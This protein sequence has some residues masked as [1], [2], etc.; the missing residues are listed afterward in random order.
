MAS[1]MPAQSPTIRSCQGPFCRDSATA[2]SGTVPTAVT[3]A[4]AGS[5]KM[6]PPWTT[7]TVDDV[8]RNTSLRAKMR[9]SRSTI[10]LKNSERIRPLVPCPT[11]F[12]STRD[13]FF[14]PAASRQAHSM[15][16]YRPPTTTM[17]FPSGTVPLRTSMPCIRGTAPGRISLSGRLR[18]PAPVAT[19]TMSG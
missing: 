19:T 10:L 3:T 14:P 4:S 15:P 12:I 1:P 7:S 16:M 8:T 6:P 5:G 2:V 9:M 11:S 18:G 17:F 13:T